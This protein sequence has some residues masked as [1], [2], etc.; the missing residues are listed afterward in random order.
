VGGYVDDAGPKLQRSAISAATERGPPRSATGTPGR[1]DAL[2]YG[3][4]R[5]SQSGYNA[6]I[7]T[8]AL[9]TSCHSANVSYGGSSQEWF[10]ATNKAEFSRAKGDS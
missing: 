7:L 8:R 6:S 4:M 9:A 1:I 5:H 3:L 10:A 2:G